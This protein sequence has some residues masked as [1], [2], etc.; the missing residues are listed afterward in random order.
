LTKMEEPPAPTMLATALAEFIKRHE[1]GSQMHELGR[2]LLVAHGKNRDRR[3]AVLRH[4][5]LAKRV[6]IALGLHRPSHW[7]GYVPPPMTIDDDGGILR[8]A[9]TSQGG[10]SHV[11]FNELG[12][13]G[14][15]SV[16]NNSPQRAELVAASTEAWNR[17]HGNPSPPGPAK[18][19]GP[20]N[21]SSAQPPSLLDSASGFSPAEDGPT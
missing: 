17:E 20:E 8:L 7:T 21:A 6:A 2:S 5:D 12:H 1:P 14:I 13:R 15:G 9:T 19:D 4:D 18:H 16:P 3:A 10:R 11:K